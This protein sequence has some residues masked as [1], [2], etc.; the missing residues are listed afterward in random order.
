[1]SIHWWWL[2]R[3]C[4]LTRNVIG[5][6]GKYQSIGSA[7]EKC[8]LSWPLKYCYSMCWPTLGSAIVQQLWACEE[9]VSVLFLWPCVA[10]WCLSWP[11]IL[12]MKPVWLTIQRSDC[13][14]WAF[15]EAGLSVVRSYWALYFQ[16]DCMWE[17]SAV[18]HLRRINISSE[19]NNSKHK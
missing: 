1:M 15:S 6:N 12:S 8:V 4:S 5:W 7:G 3:K 18:H 9:R 14:V 19:K 2:W 16:C 17:A 11:T 13:R 10:S